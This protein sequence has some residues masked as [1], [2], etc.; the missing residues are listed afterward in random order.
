MTYIINKFV[1]QPPT[2]SYDKNLSY[3]YFINTTYPKYIIPI[4]YY[5]YNNEY[6]TI[7]FCHS[8]AEDIGMIDVEFLAKKLKANICAMEYA[9]YGLHSCKNP[10]EKHCYMDI[11][12]TYSYL[13][14]L[15]VKNIILMGRSIGTGVVCYLAYILSMLNINTKLILISPFKTVMTV[16][17]NFWC[18]LDFFKNVNL[19]PYINCPVLIIHGC[20]DNITNYNTSKELS[21]F[22]PNLY[23]FITIHGAGHHCI[24]SRKEFYNSVKKFLK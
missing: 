6:P 19:A 17:F 9:G 2:V 4:R 13:L 10:S 7:L 1:F 3:L 18:P 11:I 14:K 21:K 23:Q 15:K 8:N 24:L 16:I 12:Y 22:F 5:V 20:N